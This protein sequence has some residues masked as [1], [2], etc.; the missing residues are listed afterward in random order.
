MFGWFSEPAARLHAETVPAAQDHFANVS[1]RTLI[2]TSRF[3]RVSL[4]AVNLTH[5]ARANERD[6]FVC[7][8]TSTGR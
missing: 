4:R 8:E 1:G 7:A 5:A 3:S 2:S 6:D